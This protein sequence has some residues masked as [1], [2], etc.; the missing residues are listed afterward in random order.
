MVPD[1]SFGS[2]W[3]LIAAIGAIVLIVLS[4]ALAPPLP[5]SQDGSG[6][7][8]QDPS[9]HPGGA[10]C[11]PSAIKSLPPGERDVKR[12]DCQEAREQHRLNTDD[13]VQQ[14]RSANASEWIAQITA[15]QTW[16]LIAGLN[17]SAIALGAAGLAAYFAR[18]AARIARNDQRP[19]VEIDGLIATGDI[20]MRE[21]G[22]VG[23]SFEIKIRNVGRSPANSVNA[24]VHEVSF[25]HNSDYFNLELLPMLTGIFVKSAPAGSAVFPGDRIVARRAV[26]IGGRN[27]TPVAQQDRLVAFMLAIVTY[28]FGTDEGDLLLTAA[29]FSISVPKLAGSPAFDGWR[30]YPSGQAIVARLG[31][32]DVAV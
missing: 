28:R 2:N 17:F 30:A 21:D 24:W 20:F 7:Q 16:I 18:E 22:V 14:T 9:Y 11:S 31:D 8:A 29:K 13:L 23:G 3:S 10:S 1:R 5:P 6:G 4:W 32:E 26:P 27:Y 25:I 12:T 19:W 15:R